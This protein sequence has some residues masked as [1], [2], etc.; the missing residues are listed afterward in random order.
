MDKIKT[1]EYC[2]HAKSEQTRKH[3]GV[4]IDSLIS[5]H[6]DIVFIKMELADLL[7]EFKK[8]QT[9][10]RKRFK[11]LNTKIKEAPNPKDRLQPRKQKRVN[12][13][14]DIRKKEIDNLEYAIKYLSLQLKEEN[15]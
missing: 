8:L 14:I 5:K 15:L 11:Y 9:T 1:A 12:N 3:I 4:I 7:S 2:T 10:K 6:E 13:E